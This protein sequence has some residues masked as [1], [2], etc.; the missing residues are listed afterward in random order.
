MLKFF[1]LI[2]ILSC[3]YQVRPTAYDKNNWRCNHEKF[4]ED[5]YTYCVTKVNGGHYVYCRRKN[6]KNDKCR[7]CTFRGDSIVHRMLCD[8]CDYYLSCAISRC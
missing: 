4:R 8:Q 6:W 1:S 3:F 7:Y 5:A 2:V